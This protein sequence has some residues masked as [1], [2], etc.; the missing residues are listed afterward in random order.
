MI[1]LSDIPKYIVFIHALLNIKLLL[2]TELMC[3]RI[4]EA[5]T[6]GKNI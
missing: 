6:H 1:I 5:L 2:I 3:W 4:S